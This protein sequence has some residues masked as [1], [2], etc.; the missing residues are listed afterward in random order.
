LLLALTLCLSRP[1]GSRCPVVRCVASSSR[2]FRSALR[3]G[4]AIREISMNF[5]AGGLLVLPR[6]RPRSVA[7]AR[8]GPVRSG[9]V[10]VLV[11]LCCLGGASAALAGLQVVRKVSVEGLV[12]VG[13]STPIDGLATT[14][15]DGL[16]T[17]SIDGLGTT[18]IVCL[19]NSRGACRP[20]RLVGTIAAW[21]AIEQCG[22]VSALSELRTQPGLCEFFGNGGGKVR[23]RAARAGSDRRSGLGRRAPSPTAPK[24]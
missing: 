18:S 8:G 21:K 24:Y 12:R 1:V 2:Y 5:R 15:T 17:T 4:L 13:A 14:S 9:V 10:A 22:I 3:N 16:A 11:G 7:L 19:F 20:P 6:S 23:L